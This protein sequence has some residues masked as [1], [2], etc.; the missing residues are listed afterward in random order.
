MV[1]AQALAPA[2]A[3]HALAPAHVVLLRHNPPL[4]APAL[5]G[6]IF[7]STHTTMPSMRGRGAR[8]TTAWRQTPG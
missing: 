7:F 3:G 5:A 8:R 1:P 2:S 6:P 4:L